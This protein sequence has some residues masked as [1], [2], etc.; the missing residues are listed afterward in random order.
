MK[1][2]LQTHNSPSKARRKLLGLRHI[3]PALRYGETSFMGEPLVQ[4]YL[5]HQIQMNATRPSGPQKTI[6]NVDF[7]FAGTLIQ[8]L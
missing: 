6:N 1:Q 7:D 3:S 8:Q 5:A 4:I 2:Q